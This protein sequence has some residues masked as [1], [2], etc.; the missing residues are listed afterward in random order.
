MR[1]IRGQYFSSSMMRPFG[2]VIGG[3]RSRLLVEAASEN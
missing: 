1:V 2:K 3:C